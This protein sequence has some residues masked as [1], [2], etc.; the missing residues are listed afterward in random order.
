MAIR[1]AAIVLMVSAMLQAGAAGDEP[2]Y[3]AQSS[4]VDPTSPTSQPGGR[5]YH[6]SGADAAVT[7]LETGL[8]VDSGEFAGRGQ[9]IDV[10]ADVPITA[11]QIKLKRIGNPGELLWEA[12]SARGQGDLG[13]GRIAPGSV[14]V[15][16]E[17]FVTLTIHPAAAKQIFVRL[18]AASGRCPD[19]YY[20]IYCTWARM[21]KEKTT[22]HSYTGAHEVGMMYRMIRPVEHGMALEADGRPVAEGASMMTRLLTSH[23]GAGRRR[24]LDDE[25]E[26]YRFVED[27]AAGVDPRRVGLLGCDARPADGE[28][29]LTGQWEIRVA[30]PRSPQ[31]Q[32]AVAD[33]QEFLRASMNVDMGV[34]WDAPASD[35]PR[36]I[37]LTQGPELADG[38][39]RAAGYRFVA[40]ND[41]VRIHGFD[42]RGVLRGVWY[43][44]D[45]LVLRG[46]PFLHPDARTREPRYSPRATCSAWG[47]TGELATPAPVYT[48]AHLSLISHY[49]YDG[50][51]LSWW[52]G[53]ERTGELPTRIAPGRTPPGTTYQPF[54]GRLR[55][56]TE[57][58]ERYDLEV[59]LQYAAGHPADEARARALQEQARQ[60]LRDV[61]KIRTIVLL[62]EGIGSVRHGLDAWVSTCSL[63]VEAFRQINPE[64]NVVAWTYTFAAAAGSPETPAWDGYIERLLRMDRRLTFM[65]NIDSFWARRTDGLLQNAFDYCLSLKAPSDDYARAV[66]ALLAEAK[67]DGKPPRKLWAKIESRFSQESNTQPEIPCMQRWVRRFQAI[68]GVGPPPIT[69]MIAN[70]YHQGFYPTPVTEL[71]GWLS[72]TGGPKPEELLRAI[73]RRDFGPGQ[74]D[75][76]LSAW[77]DFS[78]AIWHYPFYY[79]MSYTM[80]AGYAQPFWLDPKASN[81]R[82]WRRGFVNSLKGLQM[83]AGGQGPG[84]GNEN[85]ARMAKLD[86]LWSAGLEKLKQAV[87]A[88]PERLRPVAQSHWRTARSFGDKS[89]VTLRL[90]RWLDARDRFFAAETQAD[91]MASLDQLERI[92][93]EELS[94]VRRALPM[95]LRDSRLGHLNHGRGCSTAMTIQW[96]IAL[97][98]GALAKELPALRRQVA[99]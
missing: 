66:E 19:D 24:L 86:K 23:A 58:A 41:G 43:L 72:Y 92:G 14:S 16:Y 9:Q 95:Y 83:T 1:L 70:W 25:E 17:H 54:T 37:T 22:I 88:A 56:L 73:A 68:N 57:R 75:L 69:G 12:G 96:K 99:E 31:V 27:L 78:E 7:H 82:P 48:D 63:L 64:V 4:D 55:D 81:P 45:V 35:S 29:V 2:L 98:E 79:N 32:T 51:W 8:A 89:E 13:S 97:L 42:A 90:V 87:E 26:P 44:E 50:I 62:D 84:S 3:V 80:N 38:P 93:R 47:G 65:A 67:R 76:V 53:P 33:L 36:S 20:A 71:F 74:E 30:A 85:R 10:V 49:G 46:G 40:G 60:L 5:W 21:P 59:V 91:K 6:W 11:I 28:I 39:R 61:P 15:N 94:A 34:T 52:P 18:K 77:G